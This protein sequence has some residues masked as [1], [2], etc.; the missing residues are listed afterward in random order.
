MALEIAPLLVFRAALEHFCYLVEA[1]KM[2]R[3]VVFRL[4]E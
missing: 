2:A 4:N 3:E 1:F